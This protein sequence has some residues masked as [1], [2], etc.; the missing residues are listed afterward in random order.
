MANEQR[1]SAIQQTRDE[2]KRLTESQSREIEELHKYKDYHTKESEQLLKKERDQ[3]FSMEA[4]MNKFKS[5][6]E[7][8]RIE[9]ETLNQQVHRMQHNNLELSN[10]T[11]KLKNKLKI[12]QEQLEAKDREVKQL[13]LDEERRIQTLEAAMS[14]YVKMTFSEVRRN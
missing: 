1:L 9:R 13:R 6:Y 10:D 8:I 4:D 12:V 2:L 11:E 3:R 7:S 5:E 14:N